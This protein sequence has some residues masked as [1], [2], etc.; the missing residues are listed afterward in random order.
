VRALIV[1]I[2][3]LFAV[4]ARGDSFDPGDLDKQTHMAASYGI[5]FTVAM[6]ARHYGVTRW[7]A[8][9]LGAAT[10][11]VLGTAKE[12]ADEPYSWGDQLANTIGSGTAAIVVFSFRL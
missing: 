8:V 4:P 2:A 10:T 6:V 5:T 11:L 1:A 12:L 7:K 9:L 3:L